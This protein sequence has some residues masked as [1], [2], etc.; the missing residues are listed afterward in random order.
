[1]SPFLEGGF[2]ALALGVGASVF[3][4]VEQAEKVNADTMN[5]MAKRQIV[6]LP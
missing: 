6:S 1:M 2:G 4:K 5:S 3:L